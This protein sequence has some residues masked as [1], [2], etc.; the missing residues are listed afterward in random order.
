MPEQTLMPT[1]KVLGGGAAGA[2][3]A[4]VVYILNTYVPLFRAHPF[5]PEGVAIATTALSAMVAWLIPPGAGEATIQDPATGVVRTA[6]Q[7]VVPAPSSG[8]QGNPVGS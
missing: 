2:V 5:P 3:V 8:P 7:G 6:L 4:L 1:R